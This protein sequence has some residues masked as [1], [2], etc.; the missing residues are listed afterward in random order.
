MR[1]ST[2]AMNWSDSPPAQEVTT[3][4]RDILTILSSDRAEARSRTSDLEAIVAQ[5]R[6]TIGSLSAELAVSSTCTANRVRLFEL[7]FGMNLGE[8]T[9]EFSRE[10]RTMAEELRDAISKAAELKVGLANAQKRCV[11]ES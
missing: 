3:M 2:P 11:R 5:G 9:R 10:N 6:Q 8:A 4:L 7:E 1:M